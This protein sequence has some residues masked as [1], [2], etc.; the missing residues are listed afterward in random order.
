MGFIQQFKDQPLAFGSWLGFA[1][2]Q[3]L[4]CLLT[5]WIILQ[6]FYLPIP[7]ITQRSKEEI[8]I[9]KDKNR[10]ISKMIN[11][12]CRQLGEFSYKEIA[13]STIFWILILLWFFRAPGFIPG[14]A[15]VISSKSIKDGTPAILIGIL[16]FV[17]PTKPKFF[18]SGPTHSLP[19]R[20]LVTWNVVE[21]KIPWGVII[22]FG[23][24]FALAEGCT[25]SG[26]SDWI[27]NQLSGLSGMNEWALLFIVSGITAVLTQ[28]VSNVTTAAIIIP[29]VL[30]L[31]TKLVINPVLLLVPPTLVCS[32]GFVLPVSSAPNAMIFAIAGI[33]S[34]E[35]AKV[36]ITITM[37][38]LVIVILS[39]MSYGYLMFDL[40]TFPEWANS[41]ITS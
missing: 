11:E 5:A 36:G 4:I 3:M 32:H 27:G 6:A 8:E 16:L 33:D 25:K 19:A 10:Q 15:E 39:I 28:I 29:I 13:V 9:E 2:P 30:K 21:K 22:L 40:G 35:M 37:S 14:W 12:R 7:F 17:L 1:L 26:L 23:G 34:L 20:G 38:C 41:T 18:Q 31:A 24:G